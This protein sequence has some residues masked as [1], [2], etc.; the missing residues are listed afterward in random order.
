MTETTNGFVLAEEDLKMRG[1]GEI[2]EPDSQGLPEFQVADIIEDFPI[3][4]EARKVASYISSMEGWKEGSGVAHD[5]PSS[6]E[7]RTFRL[8]FL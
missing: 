3:L 4:E 5:C 8:S 2:L 1:S 7:E 6:G